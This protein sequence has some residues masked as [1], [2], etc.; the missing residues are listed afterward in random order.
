MPRR[1]FSCSLAYSYIL[2]IVLSPAVFAQ[3]PQSNVP[4]TPQDAKALFLQ[5]AKVNGLYG[6][7]LKPWHLKVSYKLLDASG[8]P[9]DE[10]TIE[11]FWA[12]PKLGKRVIT[13][14]KSKL[15]YLQTE[16]AAYREGELDQKMALLE[17]LA[18]AFEEPM[19]F[20]EKSLA[21]LDLTLQTRKMG[22]L[23]LPCFGLKA[24]ARTS[25]MLN[26]STYGDPAYCLENNLPI[27][28]IGSF[29]DDPHRFI[30]YHTGRFQGRYVPMDIT[31]EERGK[32]DL[33]A[34]LD[35]LEQVVNVDPSDFK[36]GSN[37]VLQHLP[38][39]TLAIP[40]GMLDSMIQTHHLRVISRPQPEYPGATRAA[41]VHGTV[42]MRA[43][44]GTDGHIAALHVINGPE[45][46]QQAALDAVWTWRFEEPFH[47]A[48]HAQIL[49]VITL[50]F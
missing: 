7:D 20:S 46:L 28:Q 26:D 8:Q 16:K 23:Q 25:G 24:R 31:A 21:F 29:A 38:E 4:A 10:G 34:H 15:V 12:G 22:S 32:P 45:V 50:H 18:N 5:A 36:P 17:L 40:E 11:E 6:D 1:S 43:T 3:T 30:L 13:S 44:I 47:D 27:V 2:S 41:N 48:Q 37:A 39:T 42:T 9:T 14:A 19:P 33:T 35:L 49:T